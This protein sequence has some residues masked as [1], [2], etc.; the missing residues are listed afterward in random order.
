MRSSRLAG[1]IA[2]VLLALAL[3]AATARAAA[4]LCSPLS[5]GAVGDGVTDNTAAIQS[6]INAAPA[7][8]TIHV[9]TCLLYTSRC[10]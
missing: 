3:S 2:L 4:D 7:A 6:A 5:F 1:A 10:V 9:C 8:A